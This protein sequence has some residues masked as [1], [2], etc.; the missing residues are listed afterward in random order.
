MKKDFG[1]RAAPRDRKYEL[2]PSDR[3]GLF[4]V[5]ALRDFKGVNAG[6]IGGYVEGEHNLS[7]SG[8]AWVG[9]YAEVGGNARIEGDAWVGGEARIKGKAR[10]FA[11]ARVFD[12]AKVFGDARIEGNAW[13]GGNARIEGDAHIDGDARVGGLTALFS[14]LHKGASC[15]PP[16]PELRP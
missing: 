8:E 13:V 12:R 1:E 14:G 11:K 10:V 7:H 16:G 9:D 4:R 3:P 15:T 2:I 5:R 6:K